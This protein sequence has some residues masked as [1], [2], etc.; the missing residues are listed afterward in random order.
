MISIL[1][2]PARNL[3]TTDQRSAMSFS[4]SR[5]QCMLAAAA[6]P[7]SGQARAARSEPVLNVSGKIKI[8]NSPQG[9]GFT[10]DMLS[11]LPQHQFHTHTPWHSGRPQFSGPLLRTVLDKVQPQGQTLRAIGLNDYAVE[12]P[13]SDAADWDVIV[14]LLQ[15]GHP[16]PV[17][18]RGPLFIIYPFDDRSELRRQQYF[19]RSVWQLCRLEIS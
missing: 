4:V 1:S 16:M 10:L 11:A 3:L 2:E 19:N 12:L 7:W 8:S 13:A 17:R 6:W 5:R 18:E 15:D 14:A 9:Y